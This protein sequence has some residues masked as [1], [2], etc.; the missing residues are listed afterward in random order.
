MFIV[1]HLSPRSI[2]RGALILPVL[3]NLYGCG[4]SRWNDP[5]PG[6]GAEDNTY[7]D[8]FSERPKHLDPVRSYSS[9]EYRIIGQIYEP[10]LQYSF[11]KRPYQLE[12]LTAAAMPEV[13][14]LDEAGNELAADVAA[15]RI[16]YSRYRVR[17][18]P[19]IRYQPHPAFALADD[20]SYRYHDLDAAAL[21]G[22]RTLA[23]FPE[24]GTREL[25]AADYVY[26]LK[27]MAHPGLHSPIFGLMA[28]YIVGLAELRETLAADYADA[29][30]AA[31]YVDLRCC[32]LEGVR[33][34][35]RYT[36]DVVIRGSY[37]QFIYWLAMPFFAPMPWEAERF[38]GQPGMAERN[39]VLD[40]YP[41]GSGAFM[42]TENDPNLRMVLLR[43]PEFNR[44]YYPTEGE[45]G[46]D[47]LGLLVD[48]GRSLPFI[49][50]AVYS[51]EKEDIPAWKKFLQGYYDTSGIAS[52]NFDQAIDVGS[53]GNATLSESMRARGIELRTAVTTSMFYMGF[54]MKDVVVG[55]LEPRARLL[56]QAISIAMDYEEF[57]SIFLNGRGIAAQGPIP[58]GIFGHRGGEAGINPHTHSWRQG[59]PRR[60]DVQ[61]ARELL[62]EAG[63]AEGRDPV[64]GKPLVLYFD[65]VSLGPDTKARNHWLVK[66]FD[67]LGIQLVL[68]STDY[69]RFREKMRKGS[70]QIFQW[71][72]N[73]DYPDPENFLFLL[74]G[75]NAK[76]DHGGENAANYANPEFDRLFE[77][78]R[79]LHNGPER[80]AIID[81]M[82]TLLR[83]DAP[84]VWGF[85]PRAY[86]L[87][88]AWYRNSKP[89]LMAN[90]T[91]KYKHI[92]PVA[93]DVAR[94]AWNQPVLW[95]M[96]LLVLLLAAL[97]VPAVVTW[98][99]REA[100]PA[101]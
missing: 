22:V 65:T 21:A 59:A 82:I 46:D 40:W 57:V 87:H 8:S 42:L 9:D 88:H 37:P 53:Q 99:Q 34:V 1:R 20:G 7:Y 96:L 78:M 52:D 17:L 13:V 84:W 3:L 62:A 91:L 85:Y 86:S 19:G 58:P 43:N 18:Q 50:R 79:N 94:R 73:A 31:A 41:L 29:I 74:Y 92:D 67:K 23:D 47:E 28:R 14:Y 54:N 101:R 38:Y 6:S 89:N 80:Q 4:E 49:D 69:N 68:R 81:E 100:A 27:R 70:A 66:Q 2:L 32:V 76:A 15:E 98:R 25:V 16:A 24:Q 56:R 60:H 11:L 10:P 72:W 36:Y 77:R 95:P 26:Q 90:N 71:G 39:L 48:A 5:Y 97:C 35:D 30:A 45:P 93:R 83:T 63:Y 75:N 51:L 33:Q 61:R 12:P 64:T 44:E 55:G